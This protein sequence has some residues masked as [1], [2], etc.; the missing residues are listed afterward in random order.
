V[1]EGQRLSDELQDDESFRYALVDLSAPDWDALY[2]KFD[3][4]RTLLPFEFAPIH[5]L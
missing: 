4:A 2:R 3:A 1:H 5:R